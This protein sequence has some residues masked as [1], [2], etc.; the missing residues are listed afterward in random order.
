MGELKGILVREFFLERR[1]REGEE[2]D[3]Y[4]DAFD[5]KK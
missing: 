5:N 4:L 2:K 3:L 1:K